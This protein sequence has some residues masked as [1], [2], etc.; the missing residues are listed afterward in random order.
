[1][2]SVS[3]SASSG[4][5]GVITILAGQSIELTGGS[6]ITASAGASG[7]SIRLQA[8]EMLLLRES[9]ITAT[10]GSVRLAGQLSGPSGT[11]GSGGNIF[12]DPRF[13]ILDHA[14][15]SANAAAGS[16]GNIQLFADNFFG[17][18]S[19]ITAT[20][21]QAGTINIVAP[22]LDLQNGLAQLSGSLVDASTQLREQ[23]AR[24]LNRDF[25]SFL[26][27][28]RGGVEPAPDG[29]AASTESDVARRVR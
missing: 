28:G 11:I 14:L 26:V 7:G 10:A 22:E 20:G 13:V 23:C 29:P 5:A 1:G 8:G 15:I 4:N 16:G 12:I 6:A 21:T 25:S 9:Q 3:T 17:S 2:G 19:A 24:H 27:L 18:E